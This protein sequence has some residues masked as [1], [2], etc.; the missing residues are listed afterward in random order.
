MTDYTGTRDNQPSDIYIYNLNIFLI[1]KQFSSQILKTNKYNS[2][3]PITLFSF[4]C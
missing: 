2:L 4:M 3:I 1:F